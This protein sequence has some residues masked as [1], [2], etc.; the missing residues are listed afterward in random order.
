MPN[1]PSCHV[2]EKR[3]LSTVSVGDGADPA[4]AADPAASSRKQPT[5]PN[6]A[7][8]PALRRTT[9]QVYSRPAPM[10]RPAGVRATGG[11]EGTPVASVRFA[12]MASSVVNERTV[13][14][15][16]R[17]IDARAAIYRL[18]SSRYRGRSTGGVSALC[19]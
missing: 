7:G 3:A 2:P 6:Q 19:G 17:L 1:Q 4:A 18:L 16:S 14:H 9:H 10:T 5:A 12:S 11:H 15:A 8:T 13:A